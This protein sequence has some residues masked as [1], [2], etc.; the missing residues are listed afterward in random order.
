MIEDNGQHYRNYSGCGNTVN[1]N[2]PVVQK[3]ILDCLRYW[4]LHMHVDGFRFDLASVFSRGQDGQ[5][6]SHPPL[7]DAIA[8]DP[9][10]RHCK[11]IAE[12]WDAAGLYQVGSF[13]SKRWSEWNGKYRDHMRRFWKG[14]ENMLR[15]F[16]MHLVGSPDLYSHENQPPQKSINFITAHDGF[17]LSDL[18]SYAHKHNEANMENNH[19]GE[20]HNESQ[21]CGEEGPTEDPEVLA[22][23][24]RMQKNFMATLLLSQGVPMLLAGDEFS[25]TQRGNNNAYCQDNELSWVD[26]TLLDRHRELF[27]FVKQAIAFRKAHPSLRRRFFLNDQTHGDS[28]PDVMWF[29]TV[30]KEIDWDHGKAI[31]CF[32]S[33]QV[34]HEDIPEDDDMMLFF[35][36]SDQPMAFAPPPEEDF[37]WHLALTTQEKAPTWRRN[38]KTLK[39]DACSVNVMISS[40]RRQRAQDNR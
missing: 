36:A 22:C 28:R 3:F 5:V 6:L 31:S 23:R 26:W 30:K 20:Q 8:E 40:L 33:G 35:N 39:V 4:V 38:Q 11:L 1:C 24:K 32:L 2:H 16:V 9:V 10:L 14:D 34:D 15:S 21:N 19:D 27:E 7:V 18:V 13:P 25:R 29:G 12:A 37:E 17:T